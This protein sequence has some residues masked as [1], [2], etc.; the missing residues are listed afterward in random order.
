M[1]VWFPT[2]LLTIISSFKCRMWFHLQYLHFKSFPMVWRMLYL[3]KVHSLH[4]C[5]KVLEHFK[6]PNSQSGNQSW[7]LG[8][9]LFHSFI[10]KGLFISL[11]ISS[12]PCPDFGCEPKVKIIIIG[13][14][15]VVI[16]WNKGF[17]CVCYSDISTNLVWWNFVFQIKEGLCH[18]IINET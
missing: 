12:L 5:P 7:I 3:N 16:C 17:Y 18:F 6:I 11:P 2:F 4:F 14:L 9:L 8:V 1:A 13:H 10:L 15:H